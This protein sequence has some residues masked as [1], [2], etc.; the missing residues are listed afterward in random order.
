VRAEPDRDR[1]GSGSVT[2]A[3]PASG[4][5][6]APALDKL[7]GVQTHVATRRRCAVA[8]GNR[9]GPNSTQTAKSTRPG[10][11]DRYDFTNRSPRYETRSWLKDS[12]GLELASRLPRHVTGSRRPDRQ[13]R[14]SFTSW[15]PSC[16]S[17]APQL[18][19]LPDDLAILVNKNQFS[20]PSA[21]PR[22]S[23]RLAGFRR[24]AHRGEHLASHEA[25]P[26][27]SNVRRVPDQTRRRAPRDHGD[28]STVACRSVK[29]GPPL[30]HYGGTRRPNGPVIVENVREGESPATC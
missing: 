9:I 16:R 26:R 4:V 14:N 19:R 7:M 20:R 28:G 6:P 3:L 18:W 29:P 8:K 17:S 11:G 2:W 5:W 24:S 21:V 1:T 10:Y 15:L 27:L 13:P 30:G 23:G 22:A 25:N 12:L